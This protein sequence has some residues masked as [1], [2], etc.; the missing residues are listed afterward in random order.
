MNEMVHYY[1]HIVRHDCSDVLVVDGVVH[2]RQE[3]R[4]VWPEGV[5]DVLCQQEDDLRTVDRSLLE[6]EDLEALQEILENLK[7]ELQHSRNRKFQTE[8]WKD[9]I[10]TLI[11]C[12]Q[13]GEE[14]RIGDITPKTIRKEVKYHFLKDHLGVFMIWTDDAATLLTFLS[15]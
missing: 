8:I 1:L 4:D 15:K 13:K 14:P 7:K 9:G 11:E 6:Q 12:I 5:V 10:Q 3:D 2:Q